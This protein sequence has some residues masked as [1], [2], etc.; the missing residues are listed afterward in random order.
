MK[1]KLFSSEAFLKL[2][3][4]LPMYKKN[5]NIFSVVF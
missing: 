5:G 4:I 3:K 1:E 2:I